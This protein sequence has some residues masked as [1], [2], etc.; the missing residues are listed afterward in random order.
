MTTP[1][2]AGAVVGGPRF[3]LRVEGLGA[4]VAGAVAFNL[5]GGNPFVFIVALLLVDVSMV[6]YL[7]G[8]AVGATIYNL[9]HNWFTA[10]A[11]LGIGYGTGTPGLLLAGCVLVAHV[12]GDRLAGYGLKYPTSF[13]DTHLGWIG[14]RA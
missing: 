10:I 13:G 6:G 2:P 11:V 8:P 1:Q 5:L 12:G 9:A 14:R 3:W 4:F 7:R